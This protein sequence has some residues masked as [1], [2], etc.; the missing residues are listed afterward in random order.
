M[1]R[2]RTLLLVEA[3]LT[4]ALAAVLGM[5]KLVEMPQGGSVS[6]G[7]LPIIVFALR[8]GTGWGV[9][10]GLAYGTLD[11]LISPFAPVHPIQFALD[12]PVAWASVGLA[13]VAAVPLARSAGSGLRSSAAVTAGVLVAALARYAAHVVSGA[14]FFGMYAPAG[15]PV[16]LYSLLYNT[17]VPVSAAA[18]LAVALVVVPALERVV[19]SAPRDKADA[20]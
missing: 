20:A 15:Q 4:I 11:I 9:A 14:V 8:R 3:A 7:M 6:L 18:C 1:G 16:V 2:N 5:L 10:A 19:P 17:Y 13:G 12:Y